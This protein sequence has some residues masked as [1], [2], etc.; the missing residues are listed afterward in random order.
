MTPGR[1]L[2]TFNFRVEIKLPGDKTSLCHADFSKCDGLE[3]NIAP[4][5][6]REGGNNGQVIHLPGVVN[7]AQLSLKRGVFDT[8]ELWAW[9]ERSQTERSLRAT[10]E[11]HVLNSARKPKMR[12][13]LTGLLPIKLKAPS[14]DAESGQIAVEEMQIAYETLHL[15]Q[16]SGEEKSAQEAE[17]A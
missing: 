12:F 14:L 10:G 17:D 3:M 8:H 13:K 2:T 9:F 6:I 7:Y 16:P 5:T 1:P 15:V 11:I 4:K